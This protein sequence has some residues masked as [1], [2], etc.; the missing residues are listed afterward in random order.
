MTFAYWWMCIPLNS[1]KRDCCRLVV[2]INGLMKFA[3]TR[4][5]RKIFQKVLGKLI[6]KYSLRMT[7]SIKNIIIYIETMS[8][9]WLILCLTVDLYKKC[10]FLFV[11]YYKEN[12]TFNVI[13]FLIIWFNLYHGLLV[14]ALQ[15]L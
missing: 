12:C 14:L 9:V 7:S 2:K 13:W 3:S 4:T 15:C 5:L 11:L 1:D 8:M 6:L 10:W